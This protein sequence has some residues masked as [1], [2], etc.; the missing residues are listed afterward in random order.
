MNKKA[1]NTTLS[2]TFSVAL[3]FFL[4]TVCIALP[5]YNRWF[6]Y[7]HV[8]AYNLT[9]LGYTKEEILTAFREVMNYLTL[10]SFEFGTGS[11]KY[12]AEGAAGVCQ[13]LSFYLF[14]APSE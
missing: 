7:L 12:S 14:C 1:L 2:I 5:I 8:D 4:L 9:S 13:P 10:P 6:Y 3:I 11:L